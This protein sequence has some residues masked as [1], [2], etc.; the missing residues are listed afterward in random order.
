MF[1][2]DDCAAAST[3][4]TFDDAFKSYGQCECCSETA[5]CNDLP[6]NVLDALDEGRTTARE[7]KEAIESIMQ[8]GESS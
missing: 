6:T 4:P 3:Y 7:V 5:G 1:Y 2:C 8:A